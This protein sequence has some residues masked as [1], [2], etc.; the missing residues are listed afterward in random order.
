MAKPRIFI[1]STFYDLKQTRVD[2]STFLEQLGYETIRNEEG[3]I[4]YGKEAPLEDYCYKEIEAV[5]ILVS[6]IGGRFGSES[7]KTDPAKESKKSEQ[8]ITQTEIKTALQLNK[9]VY[10]FIEQNVLSEYETYLLNKD[11]NIK[12]KYVDDVRIYQFIEEIRQL[13]NN[14]NIKGF[15]TVS[16]I[17]KYLQIQL[18]GLFKR[19]L[20]EQA[21]EKEINLIHKLES[22]S[23][24]L[25]K[26]VNYL[27]QENKGKDNEINKILMINHPL[28][29]FIKENLNIKYNIFFEG[30]E[31][32]KIFLRTYGYKMIQEPDPLFL[33]TYVFERIY[34]DT[35]YLIEINE[36]VFDSDKKLKYCKGSDWN[37]EN[38]KN[39]VQ[40]LST[41]EDLPF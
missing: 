22:T 32:L 29:D 4:P 19:F 20:Q 2:I 21:R 27:S 40:T 36:S 24:T 33:S 39:S 13:K 16:D 1:S 41:N 18:S 23:Q 34:N 35:Q 17:S 9:Q 26:L 15:E 5:D 30:M 12:Y 10:I 6:I 14:N 11:S 38:A 28:I 31:D 3:E 7:K 37:H 25:N 8:S